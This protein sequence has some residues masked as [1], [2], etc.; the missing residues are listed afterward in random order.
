MMAVWEEYPYLCDLELL[1]KY[2]PGE[3]V[4]IFM[5]GQPEKK[6]VIK[7]AFKGW[8]GIVSCVH[9]HL[10]NGK[11]SAIVMFG[12]NALDNALIVDVF[13]DANPMVQVWTFEEQMHWNRLFEADASL[14]HPL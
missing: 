2:V 13:D 8:R 10:K 7:R 6:Q 12:S 4:T 14:N 5:K 9:S 3:I 1:H 11:S